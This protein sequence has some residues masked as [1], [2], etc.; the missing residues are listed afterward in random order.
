MTK[1]EQF[2]AFVESLRTEDNAHTISAILEGYGAC[3][4]AGLLKKIGKAALPYAAAAGIV[5]GAAATGALDDSDLIEYQ[6]E[7]RARMQ[8]STSDISKLIQ[9]HE[10]A[11]KN[12]DPKARAKAYDALKAAKVRAIYDQGTNFK[13]YHDDNL[14]RE[15]HTSGEEITG[16]ERQY[17]P[18]GN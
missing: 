16:K 1:R 15:F 14:G 4:E 8:Y 7:E 10:S 2:I 12:K 13:F 9:A 5:G 3:M 11:I 17:L 18:H 6:Q